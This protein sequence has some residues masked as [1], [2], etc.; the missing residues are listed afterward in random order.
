MLSAPTFAS[1]REYRSRA[2]DVDFWWPYLA[3][4]LERHDLADARQEPVAGYNATYPTFLH[5]DVVVKFFGFVPAWRERH[6]AERGA[7]A[8]VATDPEILAPRLLGEGQSFDDVAAPWPYLI[9]ARVSGVALE[10]AAPSAEQRRSVA[11]DLG[12]QVLR[13]QALR[14]SGVAT[15]ADWSSLNVVAAAERSSLPRH[16]VPQID[17]YLARL[18]PFDRAF[19]HGDLVAMHTFVEGGRLTG[20]IDWGDAMV[21]ERHFELIQL[22]RDM[23]GCDKALF[24]VFLQASEWPVGK[25]FPRQTLGLALYRQVVM[26]TQHLSGD[27]FEPIAAAFPL[28]DIGTLDELAVELFAV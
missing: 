6:L 12:R 3:E 13:L 18:E 15:D 7:L 8:L 24:R 14:P 1:S 5:G 17:D 26:L 28:E 20:I 2:G 11:A 16:L 21:A 9:T 25:D 10:D 23:F 22:Y 4:V 19:V 27:V